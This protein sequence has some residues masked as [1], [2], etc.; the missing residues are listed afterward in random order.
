MARFGLQEFHPRDFE[1][2]IGQQNRNIVQLVCTEQ[3]LQLFV[4]RKHHNLQ[5]EGCVLQFT[6]NLP[7]G[8]PMSSHV[9]PK[10][11]GAFGLDGGAWTPALPLP[12]PGN[13]QNPLSASKNNWKRF[14]K[15]QVE[16]C[17]DVLRCSE[18]VSLNMLQANV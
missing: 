7:G 14:D 11:R 12:F 1:S 15:Y 10:A 8:P 3:V 18:V 6:E 16:T 5:P 4:C 2:R 13:L 9:L 17:R